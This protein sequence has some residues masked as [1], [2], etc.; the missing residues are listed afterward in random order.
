MGKSLMR[1]LGE[2]VGHV[3]RGFKTPVGPRD[4]PT[5]TTEVART[6]QEATVET[7]AGQMKL[8]RTTIDEVVVDSPRPD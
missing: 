6:V 2:F 4:N 8:R 1:S 5:P 7:P 3:A